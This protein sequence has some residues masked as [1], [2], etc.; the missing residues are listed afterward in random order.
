M[1]HPTFNNKPGVLVGINHEINDH[2]IN[3]YTIP[4]RPIVEYEWNCPNCTGGFIYLT[5]EIVNRM[6]AIVGYRSI[7]FQCKTCST[8]YR[9]VTYGILE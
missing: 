2:L 4:Q 3:E 6:N 5:V 8:D 1:Q 7:P 9:K